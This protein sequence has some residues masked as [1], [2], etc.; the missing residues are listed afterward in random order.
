MQECLL[1]IVVD[2]L[3]K[4]CG[5]KKKSAAASPSETVATAP[6]DEV[7]TKN[8]AE[9][10]A[11]VAS[12]EEKRSEEKGASEEKKAAST[13]PLGYKLNKISHQDEI[14]QLLKLLS[15]VIRI[16]NDHQ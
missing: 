11:E 13:R 2:K 4:I 8:A 14:V 15:E 10:P 16:S 1:D 7:Q 6:D 12:P 9:K 5:L 3:E